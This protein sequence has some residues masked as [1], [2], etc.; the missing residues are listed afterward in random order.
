[1]TVVRLGKA[2]RYGLYALVRMARSP[3]ARVT[4][5]DVAAEAEVSEHH[6]AK[7]L[8]ALRRA[9]LVEGARGAGGG[10][11][12]AREPAAITMLEVVE[13][14]EGRP[15]APHAARSEHGEDAVD[16]AGPE[17][18]A[19]QAVLREITTNAYY[20]LKSVTVAT[21][22]ARAE[23]APSGALPPPRTELAPIDRSP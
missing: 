23:A 11:Q 8:R 17:A 19:V 7:V 16:G 1:M 6:V 13:C 21:L 20:T 4:A 9:G 12:L 3:T 22:A 10:Y 18:S 2:S 5:K 14:I 15:D